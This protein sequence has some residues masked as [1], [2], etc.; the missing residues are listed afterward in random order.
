MHISV[1]GII[2]CRE[3]KLAAIQPEPEKERGKGENRLKLHTV[4]Y[5]LCIVG[6]NVVKPTS[7]QLICN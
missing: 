1:N 5:I 2:S 3:E 6:L 7:Q 4:L